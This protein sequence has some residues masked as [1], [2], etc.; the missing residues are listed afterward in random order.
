[1]LQDADNTG[2]LPNTELIH[3]FIYH[4]LPDIASYEIDLTNQLRHFIYEQIEKKGTKSLA[5][6]QKKYWTT[7]QSICAK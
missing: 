7:T 2:N 1:M 3:Q 6:S 4:N 5:T